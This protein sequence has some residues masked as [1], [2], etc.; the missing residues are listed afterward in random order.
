MITDSR[1]AL[2]LRSIAIAWRVLWTGCFIAGL[3]ACYQGART[4]VAADDAGAVPP[5]RDCA[6]CPS[7]RVLPAGEFSMGSSALEPGHYDNESPQHRVYIAH[8]FALAA[9]DTTR[10]QFAAFMVATHR[11][12]SAGCTRMGPGRMWL[13]DPNL[14]WRNPGYP[15]TDGDP[16][17][18]VSWQEATAYAAWLSQKTGHHYRLPSEAEWEYAARA[19]TTTAYWWGTQASHEFANYGTDECCDGMIQGRDQWFYTS[20]A[21]AMPANAFGLRDM[22]GN[23]FQW[24]QDCW[25]SDFAGAPADGSAWVTGDCEQRTQRGSSWHAAQRFLRVA[26]RVSWKYDGRN[27]YGGFRVARDL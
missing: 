2:A 12:S 4:G 15:Q 16:V 13:D 26:Y 11:R 27:I 19:G 22:S 23:I 24:M 18:C 17:T 1:A 21:G 5:L 6:E 3:T 20:P 10:R 9:D 25:H 14:S 7:M 8:R